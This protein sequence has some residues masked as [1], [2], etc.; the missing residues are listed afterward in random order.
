MIYSPAPFAIA[1]TAEASIPVPERVR[2]TVSTTT[3]TTTPVI[4]AKQGLGDAILCNCYLYV[5]SRFPTLPSSKQV[6][7]GVTPAYGPVAVFDYDGLK[8][9]AVVE[10]MGVGTFTVSET[11]YKRCKSGTRE[12]SFADPSLLGFFT[13]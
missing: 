6:I 1:P 13:P 9:Y 8:H 10:S 4:V 5:K 2:E 3:A 12:I 11:N 7:A